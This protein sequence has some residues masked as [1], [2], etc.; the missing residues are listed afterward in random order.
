MK[1]LAV[2]C[3]LGFALASSCKKDAAN[4][5]ITTQTI[6]GQVYNLC[7]DS[8]L[9]N[10]TVFLNINN[11]ASGGST[12]QTVSGTNGM[13]SFAN[14]QI[15]SSSDYTY[16]LEVQDNPLACCGKPGIDGAGVG[17]NK[18]NLTQTYV[19]NVT[20]HFNSWNLYFPNTLFTAS[21]TFVMTYQQNTYHKNVTGA[22]TNWQLVDNCPC[23][24]TT[25]THK[26]AG[27]D[28][29]WMGW[30]QVT[31]NKTTNGVHTIK[32]DSFYVG[33]GATVIDTIPW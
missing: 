9:V 7:T 28:N 3:V 8:G 11:S 18:S 25:P 27:F 21:D 19:L 30:W 17:I 24:I 16:D 1:K 5:T 10:C 12:L 6:H 29:Y 23:P 33:W 20:P 26:S 15:H 32:T 2:L 22:Y 13:F 14:V 4:D 31:Y